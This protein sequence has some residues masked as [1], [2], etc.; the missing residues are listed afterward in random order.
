VTGNYL[1]SGGDGYDIFKSQK[2]V[3]NEENGKLKSALVRQFL[4]GK[5]QSRQAI[6]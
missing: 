4:L 2:V 3:L 5:S 6:D 1:A